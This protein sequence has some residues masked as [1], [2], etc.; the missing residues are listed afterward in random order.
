MRP[1]RRGTV[2][3]ILALGA[4]AWGTAGASAPAAATS[5]QASASGQP[6]SLARLAS[7]E[8]YRFT[9]SAS[10]D[11]HTFA[12]TGMVHGP[13][14]WEIDTAVPVHETTYDVDGRGY[15]LVLGQVIPVHFTTPEGLG[16]LDGERTAAEG[17]IGF[18]HVLGIRITTA[19]SCGVAGRSGTLYHLATP[20]DAAGLLLETATACVA[21]GSG[22]LLSY[23]AGVPSGSA[24]AA[25]HVQGATGTFRV[26]AIGGVGVVRAPTA[27]PTTTTPRIPATASPGRLPA[28]FPS[29]VPA[30]PGTV[31]SSARIGPSKWYLE[32]TEPSANAIRD[33]VAALRATGFAL[34]SSSSTAAGDVDQLRRG[35][36][37]VLVEQIT[38]P[39][40]G[41]TLAVTVE[42]S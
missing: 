27:P 13:T 5:S 22:A 36:V 28:G 9:S 37:Q 30:P 8:N 38:L 20:R 33:Y 1:T 4:S 26:V 35:P 42:S 32:L 24:A 25:V 41:V 39:G 12:I 23:T 15:S 3:G 40:Q 29:S 34:T 7:L 31:L 16:H 14:D 10:N 19:G 2:V 17:L 6:F 18:T 21:K 11:G